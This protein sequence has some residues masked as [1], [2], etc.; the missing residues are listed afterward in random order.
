ML[1]LKQTVPL[2]Y[3]LCDRT[4]TVYH[5]EGLTRQV[6]TQAY[7]DIKSGTSVDG[8]REDAAAEF[9]LIVPGDL[10]IRPG[11][12]VVPGIGPELSGKAGWANLAE[13][14]VED[15]GIVRTVSRKYWRGSI[16]HTEVRG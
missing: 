2:D 14:A 3:A 15:L 13:G 9:L 4:V 5:R 8:T 1:R 16:C 10:N 6:V 11:D 7:Y 12:R